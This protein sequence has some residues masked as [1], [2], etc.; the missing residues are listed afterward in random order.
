VNNGDTSIDAFTQN[1]SDDDNIF[2]AGFFFGSTTAVSGEGILLS[3]S[4]AT[5]LLGAEHALTATV[6]D[7]AGKPMEGV[8]VTFEIT[9]GPNVGLNGMDTTD[10]DGKAHFFYVGNDTGTDI[11]V[12]KFMNSKQEWVTSNEAEKN[13]K[14]DD[15]NIPEFTTLGAVIAVLGIGAYFVFRKK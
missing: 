3:P 14:K 8:E 5:N 13:W 2:F 9:S 15:N 6:Q 10:K 4:T 11:I 1:P 7:N 12:A